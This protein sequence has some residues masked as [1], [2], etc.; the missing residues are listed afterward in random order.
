MDSISINLGK[1]KTSN[2][3]G[4]VW[5]FHS[6]IP[7]YWNGAHIP[8]WNGYPQGTLNEGIDVPFHCRFVVR[9]LHGMLV[10][11]ILFRILSELE[12]FLGLRG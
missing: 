7:W 3:W 12:T 11:C 8:L 6:M 1:V 5:V 10:I 9:L 4:M 2:Q